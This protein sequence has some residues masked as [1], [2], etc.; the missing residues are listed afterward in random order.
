[1]GNSNSTYNP[2]TDIPDLKGK[3]IIVTGAN[4]GIGYETVAELVKHGAKVYMG[5]RTESR[6]TG[7]I[8]KLKADG[9][10]DGPNTGEVL[11]LKLDL[12]TPEGARSAAQEFLRRE[13][14]LDV[15]VNNA[16]IGQFGEGGFTPVK[17]TKIPVA[18]LMA[19]NHLGPF[20]FTNT[21]LPLLKKTAA[22]PGSDVRV[23]T[24]S[25]GA[26]AQSRK[27]DWKSTDGWN[28]KSSGFFADLSCYGATKLA[29]ILFAK[30]LQQIFND[31]NVDALSV[32]L[33]PGAI[34]TAGFQPMPASSWAGY[35]VYHLLRLGGQFITP[36]QGAYTTLFAATSPRA[37]DRKKYGGAYLVPYGGLAEP[38]AAAKDP[39]AARDLWETSDKVLKAM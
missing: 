38:S 20:I 6:A 37:R 3:V 17:D 1:M 15:L 24:V 16:G 36:A 26:H 12:V 7:A 13:T 25:S 19:T 27:M 35:F 18:T 39:V 5:A 14:R 2:S 9:Y 34:N 33:S 31:E 30:Q 32:S 11:W 8:A 29:N 28:F 23:V 21:L 22:E 4:A 10:L